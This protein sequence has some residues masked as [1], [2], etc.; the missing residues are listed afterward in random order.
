MTLSRGDMM[1]FLERPISL[2]FVLIGV[3]VLLATTTSFVRRGRAE[4]EEA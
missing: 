3:A 2:T 1:V 4:A